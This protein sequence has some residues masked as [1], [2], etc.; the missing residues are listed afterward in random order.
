MSFGILAQG[1]G[2]IFIKDAILAGWML[3]LSR[4]LITIGFIFI[5]MQL[6]QNPI[7]S[8][9][10]K[11]NP[12]PFI[13]NGII[14]WLLI[15]N[16]NF[17]PESLINSSNLE[18]YFSKEVLQLLSVKLMT[19]ISLGRQQFTE[20]LCII[21]HRENDYNFTAIGFSFLH[22]DET[23]TDERKNGKCELIFSIIIPH[24]LLPFLE[25]LTIE[26]IR[27]PIISEVKKTND[28]KQFINEID[29]NMLTVELL[30]NLTTK[31]SF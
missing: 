2:T 28:L 13:K 5:T 15:G 9:S 6:T 10:E 12:A 7:L 22:N 24:L 26:S 19:S 30:R 17:G 23:I 1:I 3:L 20:E 4:F 29:F 11:G 25:N 18:N 27:G 8:F 14:N 31:K 16:R 21:P